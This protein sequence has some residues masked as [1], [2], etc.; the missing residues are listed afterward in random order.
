MTKILAELWERFKA[1]AYNE[2]RAG[3]SLIWGRPQDTISSMVGRGEATN[4][5]DDVVADT[6]NTLQ[7]G[8]TAAAIKH[9]DA[10]NKADDG[11][12]K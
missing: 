7:P 5:V 8:H 6:L 10:L 9:A 12:E 2:D 4:P 11:V 3:E 1:F